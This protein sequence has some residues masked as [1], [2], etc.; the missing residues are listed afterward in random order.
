MSQDKVPTGFTYYYRQLTP[1]NVHLSSA[2]G[3]LLDVLLLDHLLEENIVPAL[4]NLVTLTKTVTVTEPHVRA[5]LANRIGDERYHDLAE[6]VWRYINEAE[7]LYFSRKEQGVARGSRS[8]HAS[9]RLPVGK[10]EN[11]VRSELKA[12]EVPNF[13]GKKL[14]SQ[15]RFT[16]GSAI[17]L[18]AG[19]DMIVQKT[20]EAAAAAATAR[21]AKTIGPYDIKMAVLSSPSLLQVF[22][23]VGLTISPQ[24][25]AVATKAHKCGGKKQVALR[26]VNKK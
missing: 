4:Q 3:K 14:K 19:L 11:I 7:E 13:G 23:A 16:E 18:A 21:G 20:L 15:I 17:A 1:S 8:A 10:L 2:A 5:A 9:I 25:S 22:P 6:D 24:A 12:A 26:C